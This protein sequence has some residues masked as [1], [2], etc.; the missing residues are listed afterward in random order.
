MQA[1]ALML[2][3]RGISAVTN[4]RIANRFFQLGARPTI[5]GVQGEKL[6]AWAIVGCIGYYHPLPVNVPIAVNI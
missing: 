2:L 6:V 1:L 5:G 4:W 3:R